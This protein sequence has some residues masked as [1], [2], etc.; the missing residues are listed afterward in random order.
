MLAGFGPVSLPDAS[1]P[2]TCANPVRLFEP[3]DPFDVRPT[4]I[5]VYHLG[6]NGTARKLLKTWPLT[7]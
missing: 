3:F 7:P 5:S 4:S 2:E 6:N 1:G